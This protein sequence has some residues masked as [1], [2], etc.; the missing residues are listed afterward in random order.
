VTLYLSQKKKKQGGKKGRKIRNPPSGD[1]GEI[2]WSE[3]MVDGRGGVCTPIKSMIGALRP[4]TGVH[5]AD[6]G[7]KKERDT[8]VRGHLRGE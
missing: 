8:H 7:R 5:G 6:T 4:R 2:V 3:R 1:L